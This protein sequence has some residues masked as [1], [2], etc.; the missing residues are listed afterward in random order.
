MV[1][2]TLTTT[3]TN[4]TRTTSTG[5][6]ILIPNTTGTVT[7]SY[8]AGQLPASVTISMDGAMQLVG[9]GG[10]V[11]ANRTFAGDITL[12]PSADRSSYTNDGTLTLMD[13]NQPGT[14]TL[15]SAGLNRSE[16]CCRPTGGTLTI[17]R[18]GGD[19]SG[20]HTWTF[21]P[22]CGSIMFDGASVTAPSCM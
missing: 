10:V 9:P 11:N 1:T 15:T 18:S 19:L 17:N 7:S 16:A 14:T 4:L 21:G 5:T 22:S 2:T 6:K 20:T 8:V 3:I 13:P 12:T